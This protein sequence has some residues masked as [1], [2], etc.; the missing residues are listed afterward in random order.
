MRPGGGRFQG[1]SSFQG[2][3]AR[4]LPRAET[5]PDAFYDATGHLRPEF[6][7][8][9]ELFGD[10]ASD[11]RRLGE[12]AGSLR[13][14]LEELQPQSWTTTYVNTATHP[15]HVGVASRA[16]QEEWGAQAMGS[17]YP[18]EQRRGRR[19]GVL[20][21]GITRMMT[22]SMVLYFAATFMQRIW[23]LLNSDILQLIR[24]A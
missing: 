3:H 9:M 6:A 10:F 2:P 21:N 15:V 11:L 13:A 23:G 19:R 14:R 18:T 22:Y 16:E 7:V 12:M 1:I 8:E 5:K 4:Q 17:L 24:R 20:A